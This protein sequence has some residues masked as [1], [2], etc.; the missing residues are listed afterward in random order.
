MVS[1]NT[2]IESSSVCLVHFQHALSFAKVS[3]SL[4]L[5]FGLLGSGSFGFVS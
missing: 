5:Y 4:S 2:V 1:F 3:H